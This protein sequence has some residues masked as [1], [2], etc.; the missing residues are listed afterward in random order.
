MKTAESKCWRSNTLWAKGLANIYVLS[1][2]FWCLPLQLFRAVCFR[3]F[4]VGSCTSWL[5]AW[6][7]N[8]RRKAKGNRHRN[9]H[10]PMVVHVSQS[11]KSEKRR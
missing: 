10:A 11:G 2:R 8:F 5:R 6:R 3:S 1:F 9:R 7:A 4:V